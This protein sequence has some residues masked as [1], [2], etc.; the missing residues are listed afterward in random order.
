[1]V[2]FYLALANC[3]EVEFLNHTEEISEQFSNRPN[4]KNKD[5]HFLER[6]YLQP[7]NYA[8][9]GMFAF[10]SKGVK[11]KNHKYEK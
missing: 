6:K 8:I 4:Q 5:R 7:K 1:M 3:M 2:R 10:D 9:S 11:L